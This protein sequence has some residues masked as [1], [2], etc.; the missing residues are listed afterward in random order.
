MMVKK[1]VLAFFLAVSMTMSTW[2]VNVPMNQVH[3][4]ELP[5]EEISAEVSGDMYEA[6]E[7]SEETIPEEPQFPEEPQLQE[8][9]QFQE[10]PDISVTE[11]SPD[12]D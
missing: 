2:I 10:D 3:A 4:E 7:S 1:K 9:P 6:E 8:E 5:E 12:S 11:E